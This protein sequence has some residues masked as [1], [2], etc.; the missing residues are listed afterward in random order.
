MLG[1][2]VD[3]SL[4]LVYYVSG[5]GF[6]RLLLRLGRAFLFALGF[7]RGYLDCS[8]CYY[9][10]LHSGLSSLPLLTIIVYHMGY[11]MSRQFSEYFERK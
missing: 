10:N 4:F 5:I 6:A 8:R 7:A 3:I 2:G 9:F 11:I 1:G